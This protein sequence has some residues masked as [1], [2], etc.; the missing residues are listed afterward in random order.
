MRAITESAL[1]AALTVLLMFAG[2]FLPVIGFFLVLI[3]P[4]PIML[5]VIRHGLKYGIMAIAVT[6]A[7]G[8]T[9]LGILQAVL[10]G[11]TVV[12]FIGV[13]LGVGLRLDWDAPTLIGAASCAVALS[14]LI[15]VLLAG[16][17]MG[18]NIVE[19]IQTNVGEGFEQ[20]LEIYVQRGL[21]GPEDAEQMQEQMQLTV[22]LV[23]MMFPAIFLLS[24]AV[25]AVWT[26]LVTRLVL[27]RLGYPV[28]ALP[29]FSR[30]QAPVWLAFIYVAS[31]LSEMFFARQPGVYLLDL[32]GNVF[33][34]T[35]LVYLV[36]GT[37]LLYFFLKHYLRFRWLAG[38]AC[39]LVATHHFGALLLPLAAILDSGMDFRERFESKYG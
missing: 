20:A 9:F 28:P 2:N 25:Y 21:L 13:A 15:I 14:F 8:A 23:N 10:T 31:L 12:G 35:N 19:Q 27:P 5:V 11:V 38:L 32:V 3:W 37:A 7:L 6:I 4:I 22:E 16:P 36:C 33:F 29:E 34:L 18:I 26:F 17:L 1:L 39:F 30:W 24:S